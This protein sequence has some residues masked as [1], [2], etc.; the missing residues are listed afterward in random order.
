MVDGVGW[1]KIMAPVAG[2]DAEVRVLAAAAA[3]AAPFQAELAAV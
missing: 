1:A 2:G 3:L